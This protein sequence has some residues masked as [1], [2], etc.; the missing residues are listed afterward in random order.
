MPSSVTTP[1]RLFL[2]KRL[3]KDL[4]EEVNRPFDKEQAN[5]FFSRLADEYTD[6]YPQIM[7]D[8]L[9]ESMPPADTYGRTTSLKLS[10]L[11]LPPKTAA[12]R[13]KI[14]KELHAISQR[15]DLSPEMKNDMITRKAIGYIK[16]VQE[17]LLQEAADTGNNFAQGV[18][19]GFR[20]NSLQLMQMLFGNM[21]MTDN[22]DKPVPMVGLTSYAEGVSPLEAWAGSYGAR[23]GYI[24]VQ[25]A[26]ADTGYLGKQLAHMAAGLQVTSKDC[27]TQNG[28]EI[29][30]HSSAAAGRVL[31]E[32]K[33][34][35]EPG[36]VLTEANLKKIKGDVVVRTPLECDAPFGVCRECVGHRADGKFPAVGSY[37]GLDATRP[38]SEPMTQRLALASKHAGGSV[39]AN[40]ASASGFNAINQFLQVP[41]S[42]QGATQTEE[43][44][45]ITKIVPAPQ[46]GTDV[47]V[48]ET[49]YH[50]PA[51]KEVTV[52]KG[53]KVYAGDILTTGTPNP[54][55]IA[56]YKGMGAGRLF[57]S[58][59]M[60]ELMQNSGVPGNRSNIDILS[61]AFLANTRIT[62]PDGASGFN[63]GEVVPYDILRA[64]WKP[65]PGSKDLPT[66][67]AT[68]RFLEKPVRSYSVGTRLTPPVVE[69]LQRQGIKT[70]FTHEAEPPFEPYIT[71]AA[72]RSVHEPDWKARLTGFYLKKA[73]A[74]MAAKGAADSPGGKPSVYAGLLN[75]ERL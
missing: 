14:K 70:V 29:P 27:K 71:R 15:P 62:D 46:G 56:Q 30:A 44:G 1:G 39:G 24:G 34:S 28:H 59:K 22:N 53:E 41:E 35:L 6:R 19:L 75:P 58:N 8:M 20:G 50:A 67:K 55:T 60:E 57:F 26:T 47:Y 64:S 18:K 3:P 40:D 2:A 38:L 9:E 5:H 52:K 66:S 61:R 21:V 63:F 49:R 4:K 48:G 32:K 74:D 54:A 36:T 10:D 33:G 13:E 69:D 51:D 23:R 65:R 11:K 12:L 45:M 73:Y 17:L 7:Q 68:G 25:M 72:S 31:L 43:D 37:I 16:P 42:F